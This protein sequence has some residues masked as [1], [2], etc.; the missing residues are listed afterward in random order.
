M[1][2]WLQGNIPTQAIL[3]VTHN[4]EEAVFMADRI[5]VME[6]GSGRSKS[7][8]ATSAPA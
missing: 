1:E 5:V 3:M 8:F 6:K 4:I 2:I 7:G